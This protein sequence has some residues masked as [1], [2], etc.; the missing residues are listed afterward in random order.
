MIYFIHFCIYTVPIICGFSFSFWLKNLK[1]VL[2]FPVTRH[3]CMYSFCLHLCFF[4][5][6][7]LTSLFPVSSVIKKET[8]RELPIIFHYLTEVERWKPSPPKQLKTKAKEGK[9]KESRWKFFMLC[10]IKKHSNSII[11]KVFQNYLLIAIHY[12]ACFW[13]TIFYHANYTTYMHIWEGTR[14]FS[15]LYNF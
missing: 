9:G 12:H 10:G 5:S 3:F 2:F 1:K 13:F 11:I 6:F 14:Q 8:T 7:H 15:Y 4:L